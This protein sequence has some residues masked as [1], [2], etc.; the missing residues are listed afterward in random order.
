MYQTK[1]ITLLLTFFE[2]SKYAILAITT[3]RN[4]HSKKTNQYREEKVTKRL[5]KKQINHLFIEYENVL[6]QVIIA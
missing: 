5:C 2:L 1:N 6:M 4:K 3:A